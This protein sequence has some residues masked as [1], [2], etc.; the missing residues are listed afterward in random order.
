VTF[1][2]A[3][4]TP[5]VNVPDPHGSVAATGEDTALIRAPRYAKGKMCAV[6]ENSYALPGIDLPKPQRIVIAGERTAL[7]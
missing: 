1:Q 3:Q 4:A 2:D 7:I 6:F 5:V